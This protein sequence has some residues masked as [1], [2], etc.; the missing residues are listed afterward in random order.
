MSKPFIE[1][2]DLSLEFPLYGSN[3][4]SLK[5]AV[6][7]SVTGGK[8]ASDATGNTMVRALDKVNFSLKEGDRLVLLGHNGSGKTSLLRVL[9]G[10]YEVAPRMLKMQ[11]KVVPLLDV[12]FGIDPDST[13]YE[14]IFLRGLL[15]GLTHKEIK[16]KTDEIADFSGL[17]E[18][19]DMPVRTYSSGM[20]VRLGFAV[21]TSIDA[22][23][24]LMDEWLTVGDASFVH[25]A[26]ARLTE[27]VA[28]TPILVMAT[29]AHHLA[30]R[31]GTRTI[32]LSHGKIVRDTAQPSELKVVHG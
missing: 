29:H 9:A 17:G 4:R 6:I 18:F 30:E 3:V 16:A 31:I 7:K 2:S 32:E 15:L 28:R 21:S 25:K 20:L 24:L 8:V 12:S 19:L 1:A 14:N 22:D 11:G 10:I 27:L 26:E 5:R 13:G 23:I